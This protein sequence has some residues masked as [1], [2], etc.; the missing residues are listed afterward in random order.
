MM[1]DK[2]YS[3]YP[4]LIYLFAFLSGFSITASTVLLSLFL[5]CYVIKLKENLNNMPRDFVYLVV[6]YLWRGLSLVFNG[7]YF[8]FFKGVGE[9]WNKLPYVTLSGFRVDK[10]MV[11]RFVKLLILANLIIFLYALGQKYLGFPVIVKQLFTNDWVRFKGYHSH[12]LR[13]AGYL[14]SVFI[15]SLSF[16]LFYSKRYLFPSFL[17][18]LAI[19]F[20]GSRSYWFSVGIVVSLLCF[21]YSFR[22]TIYLI[23]AFI[24]VF[25]SFLYLSPHISARVKSAFNKDSG[26]SHMELRENFWYAGL[27]IFL[28]SPI[29]GV[30]AKKVSLYLERYKE[31]GLIDNTTHCHNVYI[32]YMAESGI[33]GGGILLF[34]FIYFARKYLLLARSSQDNF[35]KAF[36]FSLFACWLN[37]ALA[38]FFESNFST[39]SLWSLL[40]VWM[41]MYERF[42]RVENLI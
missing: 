1:V 22:K 16:S 39:F 38:G 17:L 11:E 29:Y 36:A 9:I 30:G 26:M 4:V 13:F 28:T 34:L 3:L 8:S 7:Y 12:P 27:E 37:V 5:L 20:N 10:K 2:F 19:I 24:A 40:S 25:V 18:F 23:L 21:F 14:S 35:S 32:T 41:G 6:F 31:Q 33:I 42:R 15:I